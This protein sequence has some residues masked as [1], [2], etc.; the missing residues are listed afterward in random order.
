[1]NKRTTISIIVLA[2]AALVFGGCTT[3]PR[4]RSMP[5][6][7]KDMLIFPP[8]PDQARFIYER[9]LRSSADVVPDKE[10]D[11]LRRALTGER[12]RGEG[13]GKPYGVAVHRGR[14]FVGDTAQRNVMV[15]DIPQQKFFVIGEEDPGQLARPLGMDVD[16]DGNLYVLD[17]THRMVYVYDR[18][19]RFL[20][21]IGKPED[22]NR[23]AGLGVSADGS[24]VYAVDI[25]GTS[26]DT[27]RIQAYDGKTGERLS[28]ISKRGNQPGLVNLPRDVA[29][30]ADGSLY[31]VDSGNF[32]V[33]KFSPDGKFISAFGS[34]GRQGGQFSRP[35]EIALDKDENIYVVDAA[36]GNFQIFN[37]EGKLLLAV[38]RRSDRSGPANYMLPSGVAVD[39]DGRVYFVDQFF[40]KVDVYRPVTL[41]L[42]DGYT[43]KERRGKYNPDIDEEVG[44]PEVNK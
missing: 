3:A 44:K 23:P 1:M 21:N 24:R 17:G 15:F 8:P 14:V 38:G 33:Q 2:L 34:I 31:V 29:V 4:P 9:T 26:H 18:D 10:D 35:K 42:D 37:P 30:T 28:E 36:F 6:S 43:N 39:D 12:K 19:G 16:K 41:G 13:L 25:G 27:H 40:Q 7:L 22:L 11:A 32:R 5:Q 20:R